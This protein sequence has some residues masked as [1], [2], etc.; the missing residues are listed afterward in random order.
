MRPR[1]R[2]GRSCRATPPAQCQE[3]R[4]PECRKRAAVGTRQ[5]EFDHPSGE[6]N[7]YAAY[8]GTGGIRV[9]NLWRRLL[10]SIRFG[11]SKVLL[12]QDITNDS[13]LIFD[14]QITVPNPDVVGREK[15]LRV[16]MKNVPLA[17]DVEV[18]TI[19]RGT[20]GFSGADLANLA[21][22][23]VVI[24]IAQVMLGAVN[25][26]ATE[27]Q[28]VIN[29]IIDLAERRWVF[30]NTLFSLSEACLYAQVV[31]LLDQLANIPGLEPRLAR[32]CAEA[33]TLIRRGVVAYSSVL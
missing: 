7:V 1:A 26:G 18:R 21:W 33:I 27:Y 20:P 14:R 13:R 16:H 22:V 17:A 19:A 25:F 31:D 8:T 29:A 15:I 23:T 3:A 12:S 4:E 11:S 30:L 2:N 9:D 24:L 28:H 10:L 6:A 32:L 5:R